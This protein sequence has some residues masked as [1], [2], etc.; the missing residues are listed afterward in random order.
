MTDLHGFGVHIVQPGD[1]QLGPVLKALSPAGEAAS[2]G[3]C[4]CTLRLRQLLSEGRQF[5]LKPCSRFRV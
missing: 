4:R 1:Q 2:L 5:L 3:Q